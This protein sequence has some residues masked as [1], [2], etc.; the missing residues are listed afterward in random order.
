MKCS[1]AVVVGG[2]LP[3]FGGCVSAAGGD[4][5]HQTGV[6]K[7]SGGAPCFSVA[8]SR[9]TRDSA[10]LIAMVDLYTRV[11]GRARQIWEQP[12]GAGTA[13]TVKRLPPSECI[14]Y[15]GHGGHGQ[16]LVPGQAYSATLWA[17]LTLNGKAQSRWYHIHFC[18]IESDNGLVAHQVLGND[19]SA[20]GVRKF[21]ASSWKCPDVAENEVQADSENSK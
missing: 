9:E 1:L 12:F 3:Q 6:V 5:G 4:A 7:T 10:P 15:P 18:M 8:D 11:D 14:E 17:S 21:P 19:W 16:A 13:I 2:A 20:C